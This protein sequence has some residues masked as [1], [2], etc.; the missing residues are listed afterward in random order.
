MNEYLIN[1]EMYSIQGEGVHVGI[2]MYFVRVAECNR[3]CLWCDTNFV[4][5]TMKTAVQIADDILGTMKQPVVQFTGGEPMLKQD[6]IQEVC[7]ILE[8]QVNPFITIQTN[9]T[10]VPEEKTFECVDFWSISLLMRLYCCSVNDK[11]SQ[12]LSDGMLFS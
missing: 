11:T 7:S 3:S 5:G 9:G 1:E 2:P 6:M 8:K 4:G 12:T 10:I